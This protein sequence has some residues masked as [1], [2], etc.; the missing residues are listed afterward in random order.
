M[1]LFE[2]VVIGCDNSPDMIR[3]AR[4]I[5]AV[6]ETF[7]LRVHLYDLTR[8]REALQFLAGEIPQ[9]DY[10]V[11]CSHGWND[12]DEGAQISLQVVDQADGDYDNAAH[13][14]SVTLGLTPANI[15][16]MAQGMG[17]TLICYACGSGR[18]PFAQAFL[19]AGYK[20]YIAPRGDGVY[21]NA[22]VL[23]IIGLFYH[24]MTATRIGDEPTCHTDQEAVALAAA[25]DANT[26]R[27]T[28]AFHYYS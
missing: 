5:R 2:S 14:E 27:G 16:D 11:L 23:F 20:A 18:E 28:C 25:L 17:R 10:V 24:L 1:K 26:P 15:P 12:P 6:L 8:K 9:C 3:D 7:G 19:K 22:G 13:W 21:G 4:T